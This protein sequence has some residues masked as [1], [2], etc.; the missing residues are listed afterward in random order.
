MKQNNN[1]RGRKGK[2]GLT[3]KY[4][5]SF[6]R[7]VAFEYLGGNLSIR[8]VAQKYENLSS[9]LL[10]NWTRR[11]K[12]EWVEGNN[13]ILALPME[14][15]SEHTLQELQKRNEELLRKLEYANLMVTGLEIM[16]DTAEQQ[17]GVD[18]RKKS[19]TK[20]LEE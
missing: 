20:Q 14:S 10:G 1:L 6:I 19:G 15:Q 5:E 18:I 9:S 11:Y 17:L 3:S 13:L 4:D 7:K 16:I 2:R 12:Q 8:Q